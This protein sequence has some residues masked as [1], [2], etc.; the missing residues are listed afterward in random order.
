MRRLAAGCGAGWRWVRGPAL[1]VF[2]TLLVGMPTAA[3]AAV[4][5]FAWLV[6]DGIVLTPL[7]PPLPA[8]GAPG[9]SPNLRIFPVVDGQVDKSAPPIGHARLYA[10]GRTTATDPYAASIGPLASMA[11]LVFSASPAQ[12]FGVH[13][14]LIQTPSGALKTTMGVV[15]SAFGVDPSIRGSWV[16]GNGATIV[17]GDA[18]DLIVA[19]AWVVDTPTPLG[20][21]AL[22][23]SPLW[24]SPG[25]VEP[26]G[27]A[28]CSPPA[29]GGG[30]VGSFYGVTALFGQVMNVRADTARFST[31]SGTMEHLL[32]IQAAAEDYLVVACS[33]FAYDYYSIL[34][35]KNCT[36]SGT[37]PLS[38]LSG[39]V[40]YLRP[41]GSI[42][43]T[44]DVEAFL[45]SPGVP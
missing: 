16:V 10:W 24:A 18:N 14:G 45:V 35:G 36:L 32:V 21:G 33:S 30:C 28:A 25:V 7:V 11:L 31:V 37:G 26:T 9:D 15:N 3:R 29:L 12:I 17:G 2:L 23:V 20:G 41:Q 39:R 6:E 22:A 43:T 27:E 8:W 40:N 13:L 4:F 5:P 42:S 1:L 19:G 44:L 38:A 34:L